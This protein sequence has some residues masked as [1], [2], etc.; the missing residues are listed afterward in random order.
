M[1]IEKTFSGPPSLHDRGRGA[2]VITSAALQMQRLHLILLHPNTSVQSTNI[3][4]EIDML[5]NLISP[6]DLEQLVEIQDLDLNQNLIS[7]SLF[8]WTSCPLNLTDDC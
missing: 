3:S 2:D 4:S 7:G 8:L 6:K 5:T 1:N